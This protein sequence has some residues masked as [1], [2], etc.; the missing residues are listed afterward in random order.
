MHATHR[1][2][3]VGA[4]LIVAFSILTALIAPTQLRADDDDD[5]EFEHD[6]LEHIDEFHAMLE[7]I[8]TVAE[9]ADDP[10]KT[11]VLAVIS[12]EDRVSSEKQYA[13][14]LEQLLPKVKDPTVQRGIRLKLGDLYGELEQYEKSREQFKRLILNQPQAN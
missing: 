5:F 9:I 7:L 6:E 10:S 3:W 1:K 13:E 4:S 2:L 11:G 14:I 12:L 8:E